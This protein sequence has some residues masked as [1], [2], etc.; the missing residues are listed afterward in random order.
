MPD[1][2][3]CPDAGQLKQL[4][5]GHAS[6][7]D[8]ARLARHLADCPACRRRLDGLGATASNIPR[9]TDPRPAEAETASVPVGVSSS[10]AGRRRWT[11]SEPG[12]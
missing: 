7:A 2:S 12:R 10:S 3:V 9:L 4:A 11:A 8:A 5:S 6:D 1:S